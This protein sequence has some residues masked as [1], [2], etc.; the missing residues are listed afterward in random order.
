M[1]KKATRASGAANHHM[2]NSAFSLRSAVEETLGP[3][4]L[5]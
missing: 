4:H 5:T 3:V 1:K 2:A